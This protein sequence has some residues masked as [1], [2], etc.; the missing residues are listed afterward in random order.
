MTQLSAKDLRGV[1]SFADTA[2][3]VSGFAEVESVLLPGLGELAG[4]D[5]AVCHL[6]DLAHGEEVDVAWPSDVFTPQRLEGYGAV[7]PE[8]PLVRHYQSAPHS[9]DPVRVSDLM[10]RRAWR[11]S[12]VY[13]DSHKGLGVD[14]QLAVMGCGETSGLG[15]SMSRSGREYSDREAALIALATPHALAAVVRARSTRACIRRFRS[16]RRSATCKSGAAPMRGERKSA[17]CQT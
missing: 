17:P 5:M 15:F 8:H 7:M 10:T 9:C 3:A 13:Q 14:D 12:R 1:L 16:H 6:L 2:L 4:S 11:S